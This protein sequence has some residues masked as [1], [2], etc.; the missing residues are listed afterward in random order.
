MPKVNEFIKSL[1]KKAGIDENDP[2]I[3]ALIENP[4]LDVDIPAETAN[5]IGTKLMT[6]EAA[7]GNPDIRKELKEVFKAEVLNGLDAEINAAMDEMGLSDEVKTEILKE[8]SSYKRASLLAKKVKEVESALNKDAGTSDKKELTNKINELNNLIAKK[9]REHADT[10]KAKDAELVDKLL[11]KDIETDLLGFDYIFPKETPNAVKLAA[12]NN[13]VTRRL[14]EKG[15]KVIATPDGGRKVVRIADD[16]DY[17]DDQHNVVSYKDFISGALAQDSLLRA[18]D[19]EDS[20]PAG[21]KT[22]FPDKVEG[23]DEAKKVNPSYMDAVDA[24]IANL[25]AQYNKTGG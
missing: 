24:D 8:K 4:A 11:Q 22:K 13:A 2:N 5:V 25:E 20:S 3:K 12:A 6:L 1:A 17:T 19:G 18:S 10:I 9:D 21:G 7:K 14:A 16:T 23:G 15:L